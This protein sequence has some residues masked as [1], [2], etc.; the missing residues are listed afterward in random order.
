[1]GALLC[2]GALRVGA[3][4]CASLE[5]VAPEF[6]TRPTARRPWMGVRLYVVP[7]EFSEPRGLTTD[8]ICASRHKPAPTL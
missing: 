8:T 2:S 6:A 7:I 1:M 4:S 5:C 3:L